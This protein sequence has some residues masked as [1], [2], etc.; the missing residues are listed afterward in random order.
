MH[1]RLLS[2][3]DPCKYLMVKTGQA[4]MLLPLLTSK[5]DTMR[6]MSRQVSTMSSQP[7]LQEQGGLCFLLL[8]H[9]Q[10]VIFWRYSCGSWTPQETQIS[11]YQQ[12]QVKPFLLQV[13]LNVAAVEEAAEALERDGAP[14]YIHGMNIVHARRLCGQAERTSPQLVALQEKLYEQYSQV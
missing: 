14:S 13:L 10:H 5:N 1:C 9:R 11:S 3:S 2:L 7:S 8:R 6:R 12:Q 4:T